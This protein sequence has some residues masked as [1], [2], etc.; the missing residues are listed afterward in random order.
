MEVT[1][2]GERIMNLF[3]G[4]T[5]NIID[6]EISEDQIIMV[7]NPFNVLKDQRLYLTTLN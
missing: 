2:S 7:A 3:K 5:L 4:D 1:I 6:Y